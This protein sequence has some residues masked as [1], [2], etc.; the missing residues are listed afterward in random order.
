MLWKLLQLCHRPVQ[1]I[2]NCVY[3]RVQSTHCSA[4]RRHCLWSHSTV[5]KSTTTTT[6]TILYLKRVTHLAYNNYSSMWPSEVGENVWRK[7][8]SDIAISWL[9]HMRCKCIKSIPSFVNSLYLRTLSVV[10]TELWRDITARCFE[11]NFFDT[12]YDC[13]GVLNIDLR[14]INRN[15]LI[16]KY[17]YTI[18][19][20]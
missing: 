19:R 15:L 18:K 14:L 3:M 13:F 20:L 6:T 12:L 5:Q 8:S 17:G 7:R 1:T 4:A 2:L 10:A 16:G 11:L 9:L